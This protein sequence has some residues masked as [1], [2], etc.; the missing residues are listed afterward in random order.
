MDKYTIA[1]RAQVV[2][3]FYENNGSIILTQ[4]AYRRQF[5]VRDGP[6]PNT[7]RNIMRR[8]ENQ[9]SVGL[10]H[11][12]NKMEQRHI[13]RDTPWICSDSALATTSSLATGMFIGHHVPQT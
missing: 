13:R 9:G 12:T 1:Q 4:R 10:D 3:L 2:K 5:N 6:S 7:I 11:G 8:F